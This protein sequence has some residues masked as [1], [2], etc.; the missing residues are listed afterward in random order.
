MSLP[1][2]DNGPECARC[3]RAPAERR[4]NP[5]T[6]RVYFLGTCSG[7]TDIEWSN[8]WKAKMAQARKDGEGNAMIRLERE[9]AAW[10]AGG[11]RFVE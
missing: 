10:I 4:V 7:C 3:H 6:K 8:R 11:R 2:F 5:D 9:K 1:M